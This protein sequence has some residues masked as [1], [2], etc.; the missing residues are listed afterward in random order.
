MIAVILLLAFLMSGCVMIDTDLQLPDETVKPLLAGND[1]IGMYFGIQIGSVQMN[2]ALHA[3]RYE[4]R[5][6]RFGYEQVRLPD[7]LIRGFTPWS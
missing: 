5:Q 3:K 4:D 6:S 7:E 1:C 2:G